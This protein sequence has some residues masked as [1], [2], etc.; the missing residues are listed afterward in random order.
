MASYTFLVMSDSHG[1]RHVVEDIKQHYQGKVT[2]L[3]HNGDSELPSTDPIWSG[4]EVVRGNCDYD[5]GYEDTNV[6]HFGEVTLVQTHGHLQ[7]INFGWQRLD[8]LAQSED[9]DVCLYGHLHRADAW[10]NG[11]TVF[12]NPGSVLQPRGEVQEKLYALVGVDDDKISVDF[13]SL[14]HQLYPSLSKVFER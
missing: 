7:G 8:L 6:R 1:D 5:N 3:F 13:Y 10:K 11:K 9:A 2:A 12:V 4:I 14:N